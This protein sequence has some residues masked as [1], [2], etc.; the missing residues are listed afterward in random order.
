LTF[1]F[2]DHGWLLV[3]SIVGVLGLVL[4]VRRRVGPIPRL[5][6]LDAAMGGC[7]I[8]ALAAAFGARGS[9]IVAAAGVAG[10]LALSRWR[11]GW[12]LLVG[13]VGLALLGAGV[14]VVGV[15]LLVVA[16]CWREA[17]SDPEPAF[18]WI[19]LGAILGFGLVALGLLTVGQFERIGAVAVGLATGTVLVGMARAAVTVRERLR[20]SE[21]QAVTDGSLALATVGICWTAWT[22]RSE[23]RR[24]G[25]CGWRCC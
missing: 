4:V 22:Q 18:S 9:T 8:G 16:V 23:R 19:V 6:W 2:V 20:E 11:P 24:A 25:A 15:P 12:R 14:V 3:G 13:V 1:G 7:S 21:R 17:R 5:S 10:A